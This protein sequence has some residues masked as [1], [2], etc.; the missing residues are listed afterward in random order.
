M[1]WKCCRKWYI[2]QS[3][4]SRNQLKIT[5]S[6][7]AQVIK[8]N[9][10]ATMKLI[11]LVAVL[12][13]VKVREIHNSVIGKRITFYTI[14]NS[15]LYSFKYSLCY[16]SSNIRSVSLL[17]VVVVMTTHHLLWANTTHI[18]WAI[19]FWIRSCIMPLELQKDWKRMPTILQ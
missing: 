13:L 1:N 7:V 14:S 6:T 12:V 5:R 15:I 11:L 9:P 16:S 3:T 18:F 10:T 8:S 4:C 19:G 2:K 17:H